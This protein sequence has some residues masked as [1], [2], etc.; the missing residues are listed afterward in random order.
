MTIPLFSVL[1]TTKFNSTFN[2][3]KAL[4]NLTMG[5]TIGQPIDLSASPLSRASIESVVTHLSDSASS[6]TATFSKSAV[7]SAFGTEAAWT[8]YIAKKPNWT[9]TLK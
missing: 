2:G 6:M 5:G 3:C 8:E 7:L 1:E 4:V 9:F